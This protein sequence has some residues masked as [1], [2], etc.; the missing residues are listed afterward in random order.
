MT[1]LVRRQEPLDA[2]IARLHTFLARMERRYECSTE[3]ALQAVNRGEMK[4]TAEVGRWLTSYRTLLHL[5]ET[6]GI[7]DRSTTRNS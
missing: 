4:A 5:K 2:T 6:A 7:E 1:Q 3:E